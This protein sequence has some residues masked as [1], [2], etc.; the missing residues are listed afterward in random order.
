MN[1]NFSKWYALHTRSHFEQKV[2]DGLRGK[3]IETFLAHHY[4]EDRYQQLM[5]L[6]SNAEKAKTS[7]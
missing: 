7:A 1:Q 5:E 4:P 3:S 6:V 2:Y